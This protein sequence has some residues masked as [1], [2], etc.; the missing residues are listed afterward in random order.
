[1]NKLTYC[2]LS[3]DGCSFV[4]SHGCAGCKESCGK[5]FHGECPVAKCAME[6]GVEHCGECPQFPCE[7]LY[8]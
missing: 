5:P 1:M 4:E 3:C 6:K 8:E 7:Q 2:G